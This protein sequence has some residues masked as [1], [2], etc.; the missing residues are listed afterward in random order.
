MNRLFDLFDAQAKGVVGDSNRN[1][2]V[3]IGLLA[4]VI[5]CAGYMLCWWNRYLSPHAMSPIFMAAAIG[6]D[7]LPYRDYYWV[8][9]PGWPFL[10][11]II[12]AVFG[13]KLIYIYAF[14]FVI[15]LV[16]VALL[17]LMLVAFVPV[18]AAAFA[19]TVTFFLS[20]G[21]IADTPVTYHIISVNFALIGLFFLLKTLNKPHGWYT[22]LW[23]ILAGIFVGLC[24]IIKQSLGVPLML[25]L[26]V[27]VLII[28]GRTMGWGKALQSVLPILFGYALVVIP[29]V[30]WLTSHELWERFFDAV[31]VSGHTSKGSLLTIFTRPLL[32]VFGLAELRGPGLLALL[33]VVL[34]VLA[35]VPWSYDLTSR[36]SLIIASVGFLVVVLL[37][38]LLLPLVKFDQRSFALTAAAMAV[39][40]CFGYALGLFVFIL[41]RQPQG[42]VGTLWLMHGFGFI[43][44][45]SFSL[46]WP[47]WETMTFPGTAF[48]IATV[49]QVNGRLRSMKWLRLTF[50]VLGVIVVAVVAHRKVTVPY[51]WGYWVEPP[52]YASDTQPSLPELEGF[53][54]SRNTAQIFENIVRDIKTHSR[55]DDRILVYPH[56]RAFYT[57]SQRKPATYAFAHWFD[58]CSDAVAIDDAQTLR[59]SPPAVVVAM[60]MPPGAY[61]RDEYFFRDGQPSG[62]RKLWT[63]IQELVRGYQV[64]GKYRTPGSGL[65]IVVW[66][67]KVS[68]NG[69]GDFDE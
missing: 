31:F 51:L 55:Q 20:T 17:Y 66:A 21:D 57:L 39:F 8:V 43:A 59:S 25:A 24:L 69:S 45:F 49:W 1:K 33:L 6:E 11:K 40:G 47:L 10:M 23:G 9:P 52:V 5:I 42:S 41:V 58:I 29:T 60:V 2:A 7:Y 63:T 30:I 53:V 65:W 36:R 37:A 16:G 28:H 15:R 38:L 56:M 50:V 46:S 22:W 13:S 34:S 44:A 27:A 32:G 18:S 67:N 14:G 54:L 19:A 4:T 62:Q 61:R 35:A 26:P 12:T 68:D 3:F 48:V 64:V